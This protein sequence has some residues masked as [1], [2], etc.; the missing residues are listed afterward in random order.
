MNGQVYSATPEQVV[1]WI[2]PEATPWIEASRP[3]LVG[4]YKGEC[5]CILGTIPASILGDS[6]YLW[7]WTPPVVP[8]IAFGRHAKQVIPKLLTL[9]SELICNCFNPDSARWLRSLGAIDI[10]PNLLVFR[11]K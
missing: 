10:G 6:A 5:G 2:D 7:L 3:L 4:I 9:Y 1:Q 11:R 8:K